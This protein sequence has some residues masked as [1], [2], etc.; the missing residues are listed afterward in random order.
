MIT[1]GRRGDSPQFHVILDRI[2]VPRLGSGRPRTRPDKVRADKAYGSPSRRSAIR[3]PTARSTA[4]TVAVRRSS[5]RP[6]TKSATRWSAGSI[7]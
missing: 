4:L 6:T 5:T 2:R 7:A 3:S 1:A